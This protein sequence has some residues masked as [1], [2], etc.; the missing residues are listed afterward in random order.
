M[1]YA[2]FIVSLLFCL[3][4]PFIYK[5]GK[6]SSALNWFGLVLIVPKYNHNILFAQIIFN[7]FAKILPYYNAI[8]MN[9]LVSRLFLN[10]FGL[11]ENINKIFEIKNAFRFINNSDEIYLR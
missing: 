5:K 9:L 4:V 10:F 1:K 2:L 11:E 3:I 8:L 6:V 7:T